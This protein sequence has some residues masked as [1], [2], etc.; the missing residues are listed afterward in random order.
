M[1]LSVVLLICHRQNPS[2]S[3]Q[4]LLFCMLGLLWHLQHPARFNGRFQILGTRRTEHDR[5][6]KK[7][8]LA[9][10]GE[11]WQEEKLSGRDHHCCF[12]WP[13]LHA[14]GVVR[15]RS[16]SEKSKPWRIRM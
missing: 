13:L 9:T 10:L 3:D 14:C 1:L 6:T 5:P 16:N 8:K 11:A 4:N 12:P 15:A 2:C 7:A